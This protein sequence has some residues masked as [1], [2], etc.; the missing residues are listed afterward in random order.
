MSKDIEDFKIKLIKENSGSIVYIFNSPVIQREYADL[1]IEAVDLM[2][3]VEELWGYKIDDFNFMW[4]LNKIGEIIYFS[5]KIITLTRMYDFDINRLI[6]TTEPVKI[7]LIKD[8]QDKCN[9]FCLKYKDD[10][11]IY[12]ALFRMDKF[13]NDLKGNPAWIEA[14]SQFKKRLEEFKNM[15]LKVF[16]E[17]NITPKDLSKYPAL[18]KSYKSYLKQDNENS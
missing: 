2:S 16:K 1:I 12:E 11:T 14:V 13:D 5:E 10:K 15:T 17:N 3:A 8:Y 18:K 9:V 7:Q 6:N 4:L